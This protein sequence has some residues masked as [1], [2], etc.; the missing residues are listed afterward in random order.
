MPEEVHDGIRDEM[1]DMN[2]VRRFF[3]A[4]ACEAVLMVTNI[5]KEEEWKCAQCKTEL[6]DYESILCDWCYCGAIFHVLGWPR[7][8]S[9]SSGNVAHARPLLIQS[10]ANGSLFADFALCTYLFL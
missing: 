5:E 4:D 1:V 7:N 8:P 3:T 6:D 2:I 9:Q 10:S